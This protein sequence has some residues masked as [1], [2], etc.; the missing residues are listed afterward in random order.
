MYLGFGSIQQVITDKELW[1]PLARLADYYSVPRTVNEARVFL[2]QVCGLPETRATEAMRI[3]SQGN[4][5]IPYDTLGYDERYSRPALLYELSGT[6]AREVQ[7]RL[8]RSHVLFLGC[9]GIGNLMAITLVTSGIGHL[10]LVDDDRI[11]LSNLTRQYMFTESDVGELKST[12]LARELARRNST[13]EVTHLEKAIAS[14]DDL[15]SL[16]AVDLVVVSADTPGL[17]DLVNTHCVRAG[18]TWMNVC[19]VNDIAVWGPLVVPGVSGCWDCRRIIAR[20][21]ADDPQLSAVISRI[22]HRY[23]A[24]SNGPVNMLASSLA[25][26]DALRHLGRFGTARSL[27]RRVGVWTHELL[28]DWQEAELNPACNTCGAYSGQ[29]SRSEYASRGESVE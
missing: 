19:Y 4:Y 29:T 5:L 27:N 12:V 22:N 6:R 23:Q 16:P 11:E 2:R 3:L 28:L 13:V 14:L 8:S 24:P 26:L 7:D 25:S 1:E 15:E 20:E 9:G 21:P 18:Q 10:T 17:T